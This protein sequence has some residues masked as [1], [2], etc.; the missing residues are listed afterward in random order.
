MRA[1]KTMLL[2]LVIGAGAWWLLPQTLKDDL[3]RHLQRDNSHFPIHYVRIEGAFQYLSKDDVQAA[4]EPLISQGFF[5]TSM[6]RVQQAVIALPWVDTVNVERVWPDAIN[7]KIIEKKPYLRWG[8]DSLMT[9][10]GIV[11]TPKS[12]EPFQHLV[13]LTGPEKQ[14]AKALE[15]MKGVTMTL[16]DKAMVLQEFTINNRGAWKIKLASGLEILLGR[17]EQLKKLQRFLKTLSL[18]GPEKINNMA[19]VD[20]RYPNGYAVSWNPQMP[21]IDWKTSN[22]TP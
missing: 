10:T 11:F 13:L 9:Q 4:I 14:Q 15:I 5:V 2:L 7:V 20:L 12:I 3:N 8:Q 21:P 16:A 18:L 6:Q 1:V 22:A 19:I 17:E